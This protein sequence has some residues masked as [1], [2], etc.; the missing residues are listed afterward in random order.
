MRRAEKKEHGQVRHAATIAGGDDTGRENN[1]HGV[2]LWSDA[3]ERQP[4]DGERRIR[5]K[6]NARGVTGSNESRAMK[7]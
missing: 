5:A 3:A 7:N 1:G 2:L 6:P 4:D